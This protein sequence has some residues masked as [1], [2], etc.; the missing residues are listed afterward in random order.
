MNSPEE[1]YKFFQK[2]FNEI[3]ESNKLFLSEFN[4]FIIR[5][6]KGFN[7]YKHKYYF[8][9]FDFRRRP[10]LKY[11]K[12]YHNDKLHIINSVY[13]TSRDYNTML[14]VFEFLDCFVQYEGEYKKRIHHKYYP[15]TNTNDRVS[16]RPENHMLVHNFVVRYSM[17]DFGGTLYK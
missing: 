7:V 12:E 2:D 13:N 3:N 9:N 10:K 15:Q 4:C 1:F 5:L 8:D 16:K 6:E 11:S 17:G 14:P